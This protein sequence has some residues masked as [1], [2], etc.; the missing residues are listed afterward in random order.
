MPR[1]SQWTSDVQTEDFQLFVAD[2]TSHRPVDSALPLLG[3]I[4][5]GVSEPTVLL[6][7][8]S[9]SVNAVRGEAAIHQ[10]LPRQYLGSVR[11]DRERHHQPPPPPSLRVP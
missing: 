8:L 1:G 4:A 9:F 10:P 3:H 7:R 11:A 5:V 2:L 6:Q